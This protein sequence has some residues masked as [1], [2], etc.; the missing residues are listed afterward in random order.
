MQAI[1]KGYQP[2]VNQLK[3]HQSD[4]RELVVVSPARA[5]KS[6]FLRHEIVVNSWNAEM[7]QD[8]GNIVVAPTYKQV[9]EILEEPI[10]NLFDQLGLLAKHSYSAHKTILKNGNI[11]YFRSLDNP[12]SIRG[13]TGHRVYVDE[14]A[15]CGQEGIDVL[16]TRMLNSL[17]YKLTLVTTPNGYNNWIYEKYFQ[18]GPLENVDYVQ[19]SIFDNPT[20][21][22]KVVEELQASMDPLMARQE[23][24]GEFINLTENTV[25]HSFS[26]ANI[27]PVDS[28]IQLDRLNF[29]LV[30]GL[31]YNIGVNAFVVLQKQGEN[32]Y[33][34]A[35]N[36]GTQTTLETGKKI[37]NDY[38]PMENLWI[39]DDASG[40]NRQ[41]GTGQ[42]NRQI[43][44]QCG[45]RNI[46]ENSSN[47]L[48]VD[49]FANTNAWLKNSLGQSRLFIHPN[50]KE[51]I[52][53]LRV[54]A[55]KK[56]SNETDDR[57]GKMGHLS[58]ALGYAI[59]WLSRG[60]IPS[61]HK[62]THF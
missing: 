5:G 45:I 30:I 27:L 50:C 25:Y 21:T 33:V 8:A 39:I 15:Y 51:L 11:V 56:N 37:Y 35:E 48:R 10:V 32:I 57:G 3:A 17:D 59:W 49:R 24:F 22:K 14:A 26:E 55:Y 4:A 47:P 38:Y 43:L 58:D 2:S 6:F 23:I 42:T 36:T 52:N 41:Q 44:R 13:L 53:E 62:T 18:N 7:A 31:D 20:I 61:I 19:F 40:R 34:F 1:I 29:Q 16:R 12:D 60:Q 46:S 9:T 28:K 54:Y